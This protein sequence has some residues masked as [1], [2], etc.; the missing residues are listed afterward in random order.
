MH[1]VL[2]M[3]LVRD[4]LIIWGDKDK[5]LHVDNAKLFHK[6]IKNSKLVILKNIGH[7]PMI[8]AANK[9]VKAFNN[10]VRESRSVKSN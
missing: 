7:M 5:I 1:W 9:S 3:G 6:Y 8:E 10:F 2:L 4:G